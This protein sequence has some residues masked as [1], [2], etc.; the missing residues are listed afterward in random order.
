MRFKTEYMPRL[1]ERPLD[2]GK[3]ILLLGS[4]FTDSIGG[5][6]RRCRWRAYPNPCGVLYNPMSIANTLEIAVN[7]DDDS[8][9][10]SITCNGELWASWLSDSGC[11]SFSRPETENRL[12]KRFERLHDI[13]ESTRAIIVTFGTAWVYELLDRPGYIVANCHKY[14]AAK[15]RRRRLSIEEITKRWMEIARLVSGKYPEI[16]FIFTVSPIRHLKDGFEG[17]SRSKA[18]LQLVCERL[19]EEIPGAEYFPSFE[20]LND[21]LRDY[22]F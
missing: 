4:C 5:R 1:S 8:L 17:N 22:R 10:G 18:I 7:G 9:S 12:R 13:L 6:M 16:R 2:P 11:T 15:F 21:D 14:P 20:V 3:P 19:C